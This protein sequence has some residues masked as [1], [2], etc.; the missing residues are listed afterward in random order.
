MLVVASLFFII[1]VR[2]GGL[3]TGIIL[4]AFTAFLFVI[5]RVAPG[6]ERQRAICAHH[7]AFITRAG[8]IYEGSVYPFHSFMIHK[9][10]ISVNKGDKKT[11]ARLIFSFTEFVG[12]FIIRPF[13][14]SIP[15]PPG[16]EPKAGLIIYELGNEVPE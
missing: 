14:I 13:D 15:I 7:E 6:L 3:M 9:D 2:E 12:Y 10:R 1:F 5:S 4:L 8:I 11:P 16:E